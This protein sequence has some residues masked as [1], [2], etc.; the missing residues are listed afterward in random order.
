MFTLPPKA[1]MRPG[2]WEARDFFLK[3][4]VGGALFRH[5]LVARLFE[6][7]ER[8]HHF[9]VR[10]SGIGGNACLRLKFSRFNI[11]LFL[12]G[13]GC[14]SWREARRRAARRVG[15]RF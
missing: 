12:P 4:D 10:H 2:A 15:K 3:H 11:H 5:F 13:Y 14:G 1:D 9:R 7:L 8:M 6:F